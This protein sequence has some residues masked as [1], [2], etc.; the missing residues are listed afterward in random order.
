MKESELNNEMIYSLIIDDL[1][2][3]ITYENKLLLTRWRNEDEENER[4]FQE[5]L[6]VQISLDKI[7][8]RH[9]YAVESSWEALNEKLE[10]QS[11]DNPVAVKTDNNFYWY[12][13]AAVVLMFLFVGLY[14]YNNSRY[15]VVN[16]ENNPMT[17]I[18]LPDGTEV[19]LKAATTI[20]YKKDGFIANRKLELLKG[21]VFIHVIKHYASQFVVEMGKVDAKDIGTSFNVARNTNHIS[22]V[23]ENGSVALRHVQSNKQVILKKG[24]MGLYDLKSEELKSINN[25][26]LN[27]KAWVDKEFLFNEVPFKDVAVQLEDVYQRTITIN[28]DA[29]KNR[30]LTAKLHYHDLDSVMSVISASLQCNVTRVNGSYI[31]SDR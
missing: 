31:L 23:V 25:N 29:L 20:R 16:T 10:M 4:I 14:F 22:I 30:K 15:M 3:T 24:Q 21:E 11:A 5:Y 8:D 27:Y 18:T 2:D 13:I 12:K 9:Q 17:A 7:N 19:S 26:N 1:E 28:G 6:K